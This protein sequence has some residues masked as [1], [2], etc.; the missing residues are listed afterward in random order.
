[1]KKLLQ[2]VAIFMII[3]SS[4]HS[5]I[6][7]E[8]GIVFIVNA[9]NP[10]TELS[11]ESI[12]LYFLKKDRF[13]A[14]GQQIRFFDRLDDSAERNYFLRNYLKMSNREVESFWIGQ[15]LYSGDSAPSQVNDD[16]TMS[17]LVSKFPESI[18]YVSSNFVETKGVKKVNVIGK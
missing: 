3:L 16:F 9:N 6:N 13:W 12:A 5:S 2:R 8:E 11:R 10:V 4:W 7:A 15:K 1:M 17:Q 18:G 14:S